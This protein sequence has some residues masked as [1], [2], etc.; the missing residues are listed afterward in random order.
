MQGAEPRQS[1]QIITAGPE[2]N[3]TISVHSQEEGGI[4]D[5]AD[6]REFLQGEHWI[7]KLVQKILDL[8]PYV[9]Y[10]LLPMSGLIATAAIVIMVN[11]AILPDIGHYGNRASYSTPPPP[12]LNPA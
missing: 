1:G 11:P 3:R 2:D 8:P 6:Q 7:K 9:K 4:Q 12:I 5:Y 10:L